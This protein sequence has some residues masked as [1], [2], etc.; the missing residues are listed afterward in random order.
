MGMGAIP[1]RMLQKGTMYYS[2]SIAYIMFQCTCSFKEEDIVSEWNF[3][4]DTVK[5]APAAVPVATNTNRKTTK[6]QLLDNVGQQQQK[7]SSIHS[8]CSAGEQLLKRTS[9]VIKDDS[10][11]INESEF[12]T[13]TEEVIMDLSSKQPET[14][15]EVANII[16]DINDTLNFAVTAT[17]INKT[18]FEIIKIIY[19]SLTS[20]T[21]GVI[22]W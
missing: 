8:E 17:C 13:V 7:R 22:R 4:I 19:N 21:K 1:I 20:D 9:K 6:R 12:S 11:S 5:A 2:L 18:K 10:T 3:K 16:I 15:P 14:L